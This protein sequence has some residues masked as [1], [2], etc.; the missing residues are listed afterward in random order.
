[1]S[2][3]VNVEVIPISFG[4]LE[5]ILNPEDFFKNNKDYFLEMVNVVRKAFGTPMTEQDIFDHLTQPK[6]VYTLREND[7]LIGMFSYTPKSLEGINLLFI[8]GIAIDPDCQGRGIFQEVT[9]VAYEGEKILGLKTQNPRMYRALEKFCDVTYPNASL[10]FPGDI[11]TLMNGLARELGI[12]VDEKKVARGAY[13]RSLYPKQSF[14][15]RCGNFFANVLNVEYSRGD[16]VLCL[17][18]KW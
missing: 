6:K 16:S 8:D 13:G 15:G 3:L 2:S 1:M 14:N 9:K 5:R 18:R 7:K 11:E 4:M 12:I 10:D 17:G